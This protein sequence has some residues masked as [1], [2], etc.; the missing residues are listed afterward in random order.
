LDTQ[1][2]ER[3][4]ASDFDTQTGYRIPE[5]STKSGPDMFT[6]YDCS[7]A[8]SPRHASILLA[9]KGIAHDTVQVR[10]AGAMGA[11]FWLFRGMAFVPGRLLRSCD[12]ASLLICSRAA[13]LVR[14]PAGARSVR[15][16]E[17]AGL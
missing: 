13:A 9:E 7:T 15:S 2:H 3:H 11:A 17:L 10:Y 1:L 16:Q 8:Y 12:V 4:D 5:A 14:Q 6:L